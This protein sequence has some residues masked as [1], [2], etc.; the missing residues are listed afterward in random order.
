M[1]NE[2][3]TLVIFQVNFQKA[4]CYY[5]NSRQL[6]DSQKYGLAIAMLSEATVA[7]KTRYSITS[8]GIPALTGTKT[9]H[10]L[11][12]DLEDLR[13]HI[14]DLLTHWEADNTAVYFDRVPPTV[15]DMDKLQIGLFISKVG[16]HTF[17]INEDIEPLPLILPDSA[18]ERSD[19]DLARQLQEQMNME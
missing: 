13:L 1:D 4:L 9:L 5:F 15:S 14:R 12:K 17:T 6:W 7:L 2:F 11:Q 10:T 16:A 18:L 19:S 8:V 3:F